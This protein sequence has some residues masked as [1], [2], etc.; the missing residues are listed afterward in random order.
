MDI[1]SIFTILLQVA[2]LFEDILEFGFWAII[3][4]VV[5]VALIIGWLVK[6]FKKKK[7]QYDQHSTGHGTT[8]GTTERENLGRTTDRTSNVENTNERRY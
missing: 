7:H 5:L 2:E 8:T 3:I 4:F 1:N 6:K